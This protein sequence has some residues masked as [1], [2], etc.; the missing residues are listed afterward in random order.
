MSEISLLKL[1]ILKIAELLKKCYWSLAASQ[2]IYLSD[3]NPFMTLPVNIL[4]DILS[5]VIQLTPTGTLSIKDLFPV[6]STGRL[7]HFRLEEIFLPTEELVG[8]LTALS[9]FGQKLVSVVLKKIY[10]TDYYATLHDPK[11]KPLR[12]SAVECLLTMAPSLEYIHIDMEFDLKTI[13]KV[14]SLKRI[15]LN[16]VP[17]GQLYDMLPQ[18][19]DSLF[20]P[21]ETITH[22]SIFEGPRNCIPP[23]QIAFLLKYCPQLLYLENSIASALEYLHSEELFCGSLSKTYK[24]EKCTLGNVNLSP[25]QAAASVTAIHI[26]TITCP[27]VKEVDVLVDDHQAITALCDFKKLHSL[28]IQWA[29]ATPGDFR[30]GLQLLLNDIG[31]QLKTLHILNFCNVDFAAIA[32]LCPS[33]EHLKIEYDSE[34]H[35]YDHPETCFLNLEALQVEC[36]HDGGI[37]AESLKLLLRNCSQL[38]TLS[39]D[40]VNSL[41]DSTLKEIVK[42]NSLS[43]LKEVMIVGSA[44]TEEGL[45]CFVSSCQS[46]EYFNFSSSKISFDMAASIIHSINPFI[47]VCSDIM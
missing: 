37:K 35:M 9:A 27:Y 18:T 46:L 13:Q 4:E 21:N 25:D 39:V 23:E 5:T 30:L 38:Q 11:M 17:K 14:G 12:A 32:T 47:I 22:L 42:S 26:A 40:N 19:D 45:S 31:M 34:V 3:E 43:K 44:L 15:E 2:S 28:L 7:R 16:F 6:I 1:S 8:I 24:L 29:H 41:T 33:L 20:I 36:L 10:C